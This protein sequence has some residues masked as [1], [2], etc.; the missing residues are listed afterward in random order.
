MKGK[1]LQLFRSGNNEIIS[2]EYLSRE[3]G[4]SRVSVWKHIHGLQESGYEIDAYPKG[5]RLISSP[6]IPYPWEFPE[7]ESRI[8][9]Y[10]ELASTMDKARELAGNNCPHFSV[11]IAGSQTKG[12]GRLKRQ[13]QSTKGGLYFTIVLRPEIPPAL[14]HTLNITASV[15]LVHTLRELYGIEAMVKWPNDILVHES[16][17]SGILSEMETESDMVKSF[18][19]GIGIN[20]NND[21]SHVTPKACSLKKLLGRNVQKNEI[22]SQFLPRLEESIKQEKF[23]RIMSAW[24]GFNITINR[25]VKIVTFNEEI[26][27][28]AVDVD[29][30]GALLLKVSDGSIQRINYGDC[31]LQGA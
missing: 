8:H 29:E 24:K 11:V 13:W 3:L 18:N 6:D 7:L 21:T 19:M 4:I 27:G 5:Y 30:T 10:P 17:L 26:E 2:G 9:Y 22:L 1:I 16:K 23:D 28:L 31:F 25:K 12:R 20:V 14:S 15:T